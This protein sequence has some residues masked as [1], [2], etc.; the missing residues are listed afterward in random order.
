MNL[1][2]NF[3]IAPFLQ[4]QVS[5]KGQTGPCP[6]TANYWNLEKYKTI[7]EKWASPE[8]QSLRDEF[9]QN[10]KSKVCKRC[11]RDEDAGKVSLRQRLSKFRNTTNLEKK[12]FPKYIEGKMYEKFP[13]ILTLIP[14]NEC[15]L[16]CFICGGH[17]SSKWNSTAR[18]YKNP[19]V[20]IH[21]NWNLTAEEYQDIV[22][23]SDKLQKIELFGGEPFYNKRNRE[24]LIKKI[25]E[26]GTSKNLVLYFNTNGTI[27]DEKYMKI[28]E[29]NFK[30]LEIRISIDG[31]NEQFEYIRYGAKFNQVME[32]VTKFQ[33]L[34]NSDVEII[35]T[36]S[37]LNFL[38]LPE[39]DEF[40]QKNK[41]SVFYNIVSD[42]ER[43]MLYNI[44]E[45]V[46][47]K[48]DL[49]DKF[50]Y[51]NNYVKNTKTNETEWSNF[52]QYTNHMDKIR[53][54]SMSNTFPKLYDLVKNYWF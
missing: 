16:E 6:Y 27:F 2:N 40:F 11:W 38:Y 54:L 13:K 45:A 18:K 39:Y 44:P 43:I 48:I 20:P 46:K 31:I 28:L 4:L 22:D 34:K 37:L 35:C 19:L 30:K 33:N 36:V 42:P 41:L 49:K 5:K 24:L 53:S 1:P 51:I 7:A 23:N 25:I 26:K 29:E 52:V 21:D 9:L 12:V 47:L 17:F 14:G 10:K 50:S 32:N 3:C 15:N 8:L